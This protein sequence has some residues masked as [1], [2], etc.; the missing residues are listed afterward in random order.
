M[1]VWQFVYGRRFAF[2]PPDYES[3]GLGGSEGSLVVLTRALARAGEQVTV[4]ANT[5]EPGEYDGVRWMP[6]P[7]LV[8]AP[9][10]D[11]RVA[12]RYEES[13]LVAPGA[14]NIFWMLDN[15]PANAAA[16]RPQAGASA[17]VVA[18]SAAMV[19]L[20]RTV[21]VQDSVTIDHPVDLEEF[22]LA[23]PG[24]VRRPV[25]LFSSIPDRGLD[26]ALAIWP[27][28][29]ERVPNAELHITSG[30]RLWGFA[31]HEARELES[32]F[33]HTPSEAAGVFVHGVVDRSALRTLQ[34]AAR[35]VLYPCREEEMYCLA[36]AE[37]A[38]AG[39]P[40]VTTNAYALSERVVDGVS[41]YLIDGSIDSPRVQAAFTRLT[42]DLLT[43]DDLWVKQ[44]LAARDKAGEADSARVAKQ[45]RELALGR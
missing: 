8:R 22:S 44:S 39:T 21:G 11:V 7:E 35:V 30:Y 5:S 25:C 16:F 37:A 43:D 15:Q 41:G 26:V 13:V 18:A 31:R 2:A 10:P 1:A 45:W 36:V 20:L 34:R 17:P 29:R 24:V 40:T 9:R 33:A 4:Y 14:R 12:V 32:R 6:L 27:H 3:P 38:A 42:A 19:R 23:E 28:L